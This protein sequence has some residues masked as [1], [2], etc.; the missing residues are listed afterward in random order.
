MLT[1]WGL[2]KFLNMAKAW[3]KHIS[4]LGKAK[5]EASSGPGLELFV[6]NEG[7]LCSMARDKFLTSQSKEINNTGF[8]VTNIV[9]F[10]SLLQL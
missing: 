4:S 5:P 6:V 9:S 7:E 2:T 1:E 10:T 3:Q 8:Y